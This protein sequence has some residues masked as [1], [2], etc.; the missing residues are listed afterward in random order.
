MRNALWHDIKAADLLARVA[1][2]EG[3]AS[4]SAPVTITPAIGAPVTPHAVS[5]VVAYSPVGDSSL[6][7]GGGAPVYEYDDSEEGDALYGEWRTDEYGIPYFVSWA[8]PLVEMLYRAQEAARESGDRVS[9][10]GF[11]H[12][13]DALLRV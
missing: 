12:R 1:T 8:T 10:W 6:T 11:T 2:Q 7:G 9:Y 4:H 5:P 13:I 3:G